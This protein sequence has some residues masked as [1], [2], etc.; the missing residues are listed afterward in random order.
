[1]EMPVQTPVSGMTAV[2]TNT[3]AKL[4]LLAIERKL[5][6]TLISLGD[7]IHM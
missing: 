3:H 2:Y 4:W 7:K 5:R 1:M 6:Q